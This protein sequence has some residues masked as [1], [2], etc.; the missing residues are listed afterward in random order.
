MLLLLEGKDNVCRFREAAAAL[1]RERRLPASVRIVDTA[2][3][4]AEEERFEDCR[5]AVE[6]ADLVLL[7]LHGS[8]AYFRS[9]SRLKET[10]SERTYCF[11]SG[12]E[13]ENA[14]MR[15]Q[16]GLTDGEYGRI[17][18][19]I[20]AGG[21]ENERRLLEYLAFCI[22]LTEE[23]PSA[24]LL[25]PRDGIYRADGMNR[26]NRVDGIDGEEESGRLRWCGEGGGPL[27]GILVHYYNVAND[28]TEHIDELIGSVREAGGRPFPIYSS[29]TAQPGLGAPGLKQVME[30]YWME[31]GVSIVDAVLVTCGFSLTVL[32]RPGGLDGAAAD[33][34]DGAGLCAPVEYSVFQELNVPVIQAMT[35]GMTP[36]QWEASAMGIDA[37][38]LSANVYQTETDGQLIGAVIAG[39]DTVETDSGSRWKYVPVKEQAR[40]A[41]RLAVNWARLRRT[42]ME[43]KRIA[44]IL[45]NMPPR[46]DQ[47][48]CAYGLDT[49]KSLEGILARLLEQGV[50]TEWEPQELNEIFGRVTRGLT[51]DNRLLSEAEQEKRSAAIVSE[52]QYREWFCEL[53]ETVREQL[54]ADWGEPPGPVLTSGSGFLI[55]G[56]RS[57]NLFVGIQPP[58]GLEEQ[59]EELC[60][61]QQIACPHQYLAFYRWLTRSF[62]AHAVIHLGTHGTAEWLPGKSCGL[63]ERCYPLQ[64]LDC[65]PNIYPYVLDVVGE[66]MQARRRS[67]ACII[68]HLPPSVKKAGLY[69]SLLELE[70]LCDEYRKARESDPAK[71]GL[72]KEQLWKR[73][74]SEGMEAELGL[75]RSCFFGETEAA[76]DRLH[77]R[78][79]RLRDTQIKDGFHIFGEPP[80]PVQ[81]R[82]LTAAILEA[83]AGEESK[84]LEE[85]AE[86]RRAAEERLEDTLLQAD[87]EL[88]SLLA[89][90]SGEFVA[91]GP[92]GCL[93]RRG[94][95]LLPTGRNFH[96]LDPASVP[97][98]AAWETG[99]RLADQLLNKYK[100]DEGRF[101]ETLAIVV[102]SGDVMRTGGDDIAE[103]MYLYGIRP[104]WQGGSHTVIGLEVIPSRELGRPR[105]DVV[106]R[107]SGLF[108]DTFPNLIE[109]IEDAVNLAASLP[110]PAETN[111][112]RKHILEDV[113]SWQA[114]GLNREEAELRAG[115]RIFGCPPGGYGAGV[116]SLIHSGKWSEGKDLAEAYLAWSGFA[117]GRNVHGAKLD[118]VFKRQLSRVNAT[119]KNIASYET[120]LLDDD[121]FYIYHGGLIRAVK[122]SGGQ[123]PKAYS[124]VSDGRRETIDSVEDDMARILRARLVN[125]AWLEGLKRHGFRGAQ[126]VSAAVDMVFGWDATARA[127]EDW[128]YEAIA[129]CFIKNEENRRWL[130]TENPWALQAVCGR[131]LEAD[132]RKLWAA[133]S[134]TVRLLQENY[135]KLE[136]ILEEET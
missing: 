83:K 19:Y 16:S 6:K 68:S 1:E 43:G 56:L 108:R 112:I 117:Y 12:I 3:V 66:G 33:H 17:T 103:I 121:D 100:E 50:K 91:P 29:M 46:R 2:Q 118:G 39:C 71:T 55:P 129:D 106:L 123:F 48:G 74:V 69:G 126:E 32:N 89:A 65:V 11:Y 21:K 8:I 53:P 130:E 36:E 25:L 109:R 92:G 27:I 99:K 94:E 7:W 47:I 24:P 90:L 125:P 110:E 93:S 119:V 41:A 133:K 42:P 67:A 80:G 61:S 28:D 115:L 64:A 135:L 111:Y 13:A 128:M 63:S 18:A 77:N 44:V 124:A 76:L 51:N 52:E 86:L 120:D 96:T 58:R 34:E 131:L 15:R 54:T 60:H 122:E 97:D 136:G 132:Q 87:C 116:D 127:A 59:A 105:I 5:S 73:I 101:P 79:I 107:I 57:G 4:D 26:N 102:Y 49:P 78:L 30:T 104:V 37:M 35:M 70:E 9:F 113:E 23:P 84:L 72:R 38:S 81:R 31:G 20:E 10:L 88:D 134:G 114:V 95:E 22:G 85:Q 82:Q 14:E 40:R 45:H 75:D 98:R 62:R